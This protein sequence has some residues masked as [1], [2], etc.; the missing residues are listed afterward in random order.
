[1]L[2]P[3]FERTQDV[4]TYRGRFPVQLEIPYSSTLSP[5]D[6]DMIGYLASWDRDPNTAEGFEGGRSVL[7]SRERPVRKGP[8]ELSGLQIS[9]IGYKEF[10]YEGEIVLTD[11]NSP[12]H[13][14]SAENFMKYIKG[15]KMSTSR[16]EGNRI[17]TTRPSYRAKGTYILP[18]LAEKI[19]RTDEISAVNFKNINVPHVEAYG[20][21]L[22]MGNNDGNFGFVVFPVPG[23][24]QRMFQEA[25][26]WFLDKD[27]GVSDDPWVTLMKYYYAMSPGMSVLA[28]GLRELHDRGYAHLQTHLSNLYFVNGMPYLMDW[29]TMIRLGNDRNENVLNRTLD[30]KKPGDNY[31]AVYKSIFR[32]PEPV[33]I[34]MFHLILELLMESYSGNVERE[35]DFMEKFYRAAEVIGN[36]ATELDAIA[37]WMRDEGFEGSFSRI[38]EKNAYHIIELSKPQKVGRNDPCPCGSGMKYKRCCGG[39]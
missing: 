21:Y 14:P 36:N 11:D 26:R 16:A 5:S 4:R 15:T 1:M 34:K 12:M 31:E 20:R 27:S 22:E 10:E 17:V 13:P 35:I 8:L 2:K 29:A 18:E 6:I 3:L 30:L 9:G 28:A 23:I 37:Q 32:I 25:I 38:K 39:H 19:K 24:R 7:I 33:S